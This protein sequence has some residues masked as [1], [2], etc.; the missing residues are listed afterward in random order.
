MNGT[1]K[2]R[3][4]DMLIRAGAV[5]GTLGAA[6]MAIKLKMTVTPG[7]Q[8]VFFYKEMLAASAVM[9]VLGAWYG[10]QGRIEQE[11]EEKKL[12]ELEAPSEMPLADEPVA[13]RDRRSTS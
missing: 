3:L 5:V 10:R 11:E 1:V 12:A 13:S 8:E 6:A 9:L 7:V 2:K 4:G